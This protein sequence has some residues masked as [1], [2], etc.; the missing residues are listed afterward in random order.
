MVCAALLTGCGFLPGSGPHEQIINS[1]ASAAMPNLSETVGYEYVVVDVT[2]AILPL[3]SADRQDEFRSFGAARSG[4]PSIRLGPGDVIRVTVFE[5]Q[6][7]GLFLPDDAGARPG[8]FVQLPPQRVDQEGRISVPFAGTIVAQGQTPT[9]IERVIRSRLEGRAIEPEVS[10]EIVEQNFSRFSVI[11]RVGSSG[12]FSLR[13]GGVRILEAIAQAGGISGPAAATFVTLRR[14]NRSVKVAYQAITENPSENIYLAPGDVIEVTVEERAFFAFGATGLI[15]NFD[16]GSD[17]VT[18]NQ[19]IARVASV[20]EFR[21][22][23]RQVLIYRTESR[24]A[25]ERMGVDLSG[26]RDPMATTI[27]TIYRANYRSPD[28]FFLAHE[29]KMRDNDVLYV[30]NAAS[31]EI[32][33]FFSNVNTVAAQPL[34]LRNIARAY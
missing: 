25:L 27:N 22:N 28:I 33:R 15:G 12:T 18:L 6:T 21:A 14:G 7:G 20:L 30:T 19:A 5:S 8:N 4:P 11:G 29:F 32:Q 13:E 1:N 23:P 24:A 10:V 17:E 9:A 2:R 34:Q 3:M 16:F 31:I 26:L